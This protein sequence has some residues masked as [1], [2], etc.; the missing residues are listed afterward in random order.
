[1]AATDQDAVPRR[2][3]TPLMHIKYRENN[4]SLLFPMERYPHFE[5][6]ILGYELVSVY[7]AMSEIAMIALRQWEK[8]RAH[9]CYF[10]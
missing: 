7:H 2:S 10:S 6:D 8:Y 3:G 1:V 4:D 9:K 5:D